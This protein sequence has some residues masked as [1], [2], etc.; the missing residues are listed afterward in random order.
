MII[1]SLIIYRGINISL[2]THVNQWSYKLTVEGSHMTTNN[3][4]F[5]ASAHT[6]IKTFP[7]PLHLILPLSVYSQCT[8]THFIGKF[9][10]WQKWSKNLETS[11]ICTKFQTP[12]SGVTRKVEG[13]TVPGIAQGAHN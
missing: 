12:N 8:S 11:S 1:L 9:T 13:E 4:T 10:T 2:E 3:F 6:G 5:L 7:L